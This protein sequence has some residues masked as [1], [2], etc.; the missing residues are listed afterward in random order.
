MCRQAM[1]LAAGRGSRL[2]PLT[3]KIP[4][5]LISIKGKPLVVYH[6]ERLVRMKVDS[7]VINTG[8]LG[9]MLES[10][11]GDGSKW[12]VSIS[13]SREITDTGSILG[14]ASGI[15]YAVDK[16]LLTEDIFFVINADVWT[17]FCS[18]DNF[19]LANNVQY[20]AHLFLIKVINNNSDFSLSSSGV[21]FLQENNIY[22]FCG[23]GFYRKH[24]FQDDETSAAQL[25]DMIKH[26]VQDNKVSGSVYPGIWQDMGT[27][28]RILTVDPYFL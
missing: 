19:L 24:I 12:G 10:Y 3:D 1:I 25:G 28:D 20:V 22:T 26:Y 14:T 23:M 15:R 2:R 8:W 7:I 11:L 6:I 16:K 18:W 21:V 17:D 13:Y 4:K 5:S 27:I 9:E